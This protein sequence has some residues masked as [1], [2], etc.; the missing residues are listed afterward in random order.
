MRLLISA[1]T[2]LMLFATPVVA[3]DLKDAVAAYTAG[4]YQKALRLFKPLAERGNLSAQHNLGVM[5]RTGNFVLIFGQLI[6]I[7]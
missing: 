1:L 7:P 2:A 5:Y 3:G 4:D 6:L